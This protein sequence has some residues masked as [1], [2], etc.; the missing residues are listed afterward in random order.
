MMK[1]ISLRLDTE[2]ITHFKRIAYQRCLDENCDITYNDLILE[3]ALE[4]YPIAETTAKSQTKKGEE[5]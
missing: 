2:E 5:K 4:K 1:T 3:A